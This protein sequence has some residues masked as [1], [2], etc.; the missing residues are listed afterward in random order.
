MDGLTTTTERSSNPMVAGS[1]PAGRTLTRHYALIHAFVDHARDKSRNKKGTLAPTGTLDVV[2][3]LAA[4]S[5]TQGARENTWLV[6][7]RGDHPP[8]DPPP[9]RPRYVDGGAR[10]RAPILARPEDA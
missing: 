3:G 7:R 6:S 9:R 2:V 10:R 1:I 8:R 4:R 5:W